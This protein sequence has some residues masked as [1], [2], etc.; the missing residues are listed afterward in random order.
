MDN[1]KKQHGESRNTDKASEQDTILIQLNISLLDRTRLYQEIR[2]E[3]GKDQGIV[4]V[5]MKGIGKGS[6]MATMITSL[7]LGEALWWLEEEMLLSERRWSDSLQVGII[8]VAAG[9]VSVMVI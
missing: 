6:V 4:W 9:V 7:G 3:M 8:M 1:K 5:S 2:L